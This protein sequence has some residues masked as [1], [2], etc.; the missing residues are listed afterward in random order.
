MKEI[1]VLNENGQPELISAGVERYEELQN[2]PIQTIFKGVLLANSTVSYDGEELVLTA[3]EGHKWSEQELILF[4]NYAPSGRYDIISES[5]SYELLTIDASNQASR[6]YRRSNV[7]SDEIWI[8]TTAGDGTW[9]AVTDTNAEKLIVKFLN[10]NE[11]PL[12]LVVG[13]PLNFRFYYYSTRG[14]ATIRATITTPK[15]SDTYTIGVVAPGNEVDVNIGKY[16]VDGSNEIS[17]QFE[18]SAARE[19]VAY[20]SINGVDASYEPAFNKYQAFKTNILFPYSCSSSSKKVVYFEITNAKGE[21]Q[22]LSNSHAY[23]SAAD[24]FVNGNIELTAELFSHGINTISTYMVAVGKNGGQE[25]EMARTATYVYQI[26]YLTTLEPIL[27]VYVD[28][29]E[30]LK[31]Y[32]SL[33]VPYYIWS[34]EA[35][36]ADKI[37]FALSYS[38]ND[39]KILSSEHVSSEPGAITNYLQFN[40]LHEWL[41]SSL[42][43]S[44]LDEDSPERGVDFNIQATYKENALPPYV[45]SKVKIEPQSGAMQPVGNAKFSFNAIDYSQNYA[46][47]VWT[48]IGKTKKSLVFNNYNAEIDGLRSDEEGNQYVNLSSNTTARLSEATNPVFGAYDTPFTLE[49]SFKV[50]ESTADQPIIKYYSETAP[51]NT[52]GLTIY[53]NKASIKLSGK[54]EPVDIFYSAGE[55]IH[56]TYVGFHKT[57]T[58]IDLDDNDTQVSSMLTYLFIYLNGIL[59]KMVELD[60]SVGLPNEAGTIDFNI[61]N[62][63]LNLYTFRGYDISLTSSQVLQ[64]YISNFGNAD[65]KVEMYTK[66]NLYDY[67]QATGVPGESAISFAETVGKIPCYVLVCDRLPRSKSYVD[68]LGIYYEKHGENLVE[69]GNYVKKMKQDLTGISKATTYYY[70]RETLYNEDGT[71]KLDENGDQMYG[72]W[73]RN[74][75]IEVGGQGTS[76]MKYPRHNL[77]FK[78]NKNNKFYIKGHKD[79]PDRTF[80]FKA[81]YMDSSGANNICNAQIMENALMREK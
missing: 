33:N 73:M 48:S 11:I 61:N 64:N 78:H 24:A 39:E 43:A 13:D 74:K 19:T 50:N 63:G 77:K 8:E 35:G 71:P 75:P 40:T 34:L 25:Y 4:C 51:S 32:A 20:K 72:P 22:V 60:S 80:T 38:D 14:S 70:Y 66:N 3:A 79:G 9:K 26:P 49:V 46:D 5:R 56:L 45:Q 67:K 17:I 2:A 37:N 18:N 10:E 29:W 62:T 44:R 21:T 6:K 27:M 16:I 54:A 68:C 41:I 57:A 7:S 55:R 31:Q 59:S 36:T 12:S 52:T 42:P 47:G 53:P 81:D 58:D 30:G 1:Y 76:S 28:S 23:S 69:P 15:G 65:T